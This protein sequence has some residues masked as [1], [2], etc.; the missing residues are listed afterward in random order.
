M[1]D[2]V[3]Y[4]ALRKWVTGNRGP[5]AA[6][7]GNHNAGRLLRTLREEEQRDQEIRKKNRIVEGERKEIGE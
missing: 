2:W 1:M 6:I 7:R 4:V 5:E 3:A